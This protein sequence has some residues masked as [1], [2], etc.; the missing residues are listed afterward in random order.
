MRL[1][2]ITLPYFIQDEASKIVELLESGLVDRV[3]VRKPGSSQEEIANL[4]EGIPLYYHPQISLHDGFDLLKRYN[5][6]GVHLSRRNPSFSSGYK[7]LVSKSCHTLE[8]L[9][10]CDYYFLSPVFDSISKP[11]YM[12]SWSI[13]ELNGRL[14]GNVYALG[15][16]TPDK[17]PI[18]DKTGFIGGAILGAA[19]YGDAN[20]FLK[21]VE[22][23]KALC[24]NS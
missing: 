5:V 22:Y 12:S 3:H 20:E 2:V 6:G 14:K 24:C 1:I 11:G 13:E 7:V 23:Y 9:E 16:V 18:L 4:I 21:N 10:G 19:W 17:L 15:G 8:E